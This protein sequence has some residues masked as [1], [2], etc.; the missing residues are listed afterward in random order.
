M[1]SLVVGM[2]PSR[3]GNNASLR[4]LFPLRGPGKPPGRKSSKEGER[5]Q[6]SPS[7]SDPQKRGK[8][9]EKLQK[10]H[11]GVNFLPLFGGNFPHFR[12]AEIGSE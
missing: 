1:L 8:I 5:L 11:F 10:L 3:G 2:F 6:N 9:T 7:R 4:D 12:V